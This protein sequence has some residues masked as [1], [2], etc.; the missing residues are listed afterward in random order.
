MAV[1]TTVGFS[2]DTPRLTRFILKI[3]VDL[4]LPSGLT[5]KEAHVAT[6]PCHRQNDLVVLP[7]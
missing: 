7:A 5:F 6:S 4:G 1:G 2:F 3:P